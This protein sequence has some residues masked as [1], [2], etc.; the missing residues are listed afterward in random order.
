MLTNCV[1]TQQAE[2]DAQLAPIASS[3]SSILAVAIIAPNT[4]DERSTLFQRQRQDSM[5]P[6]RCFCTS[7]E[8]GIG[9]GSATRYHTFLGDELTQASEVNPI[10]SCSAV[11][12]PALSFGVGDGRREPGAVQLNVSHGY[13]VYPSAGHWRSSICPRGD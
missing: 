8:S 5:C 11:G 2:L 3:T 12:E 6:L 13:F 7:S 10:F 9:G 4:S 1:L